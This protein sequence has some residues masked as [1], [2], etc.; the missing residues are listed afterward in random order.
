[1]AE[2]CERLAGQHEDGRVNRAISIG[3]LALM[4]I[5][6]VCFTLYVKAAHE[7]NGTSDA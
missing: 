3:S 1:M 5:N 2:V 7:F 6:I 4:T